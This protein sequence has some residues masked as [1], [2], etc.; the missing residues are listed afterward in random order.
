MTCVSPANRTNLFNLKLTGTENNPSPAPAKRGY[1]QDEDPGRPTWPGV[2]R[3]RRLMN[4]QEKDRVIVESLGECWHEWEYYSSYRLAGEE[5]DERCVK[6]KRFK[7]ELKVDSLS[8]WEG[9]GWWWERAQKMEW[10]VEF[11]VWLQHKY[12]RSN[13]Q[14]DVRMI[15]IVFTNPIRGRDA[16]YEFLL[17]RSKGR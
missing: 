16:L 9:F 17:G 2:G 15:P 13:F 3:S 14:Y 11:I 10:W 8:T 6:C 4:D 5:S 7:S 12:L 1:I